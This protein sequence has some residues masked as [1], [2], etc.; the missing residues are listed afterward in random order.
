M[1]N[2]RT[3]NIFFD[4]LCGSFVHLSCD[5]VGE[6]NSKNTGRVHILVGDEVGNTISEDSGLA[7]TSA[8]DDS[9]ILGIGGHSLILFVI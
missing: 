8:R 4:E 2:R 3:S 6:G 9:H 5:L 7:R 1:K